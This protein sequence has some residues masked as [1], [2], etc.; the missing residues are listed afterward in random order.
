MSEIFAVS[1]RENASRE[2]AAALATV[3]NSYL[4]RMTQFFWTYST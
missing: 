4:T 1:Q 2:I 3:T